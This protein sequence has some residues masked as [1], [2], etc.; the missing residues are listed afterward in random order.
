MSSRHRAR[1]LYNILFII[2]FIATTV[3]QQQPTSK[4]ASGAP[5]VELPPVGFEP[6]NN[7]IRFYANR[8]DGLRQ[9]G[10]GQVHIYIYIYIYIYRYRYIY[11]CSQA[12]EPV[13]AEKRG[14]AS[15][16][17]RLRKW[18]RVGFRDRFKVGGVARLGACRA[19]G[20][21]SAPRRMSVSEPAARAAQ[22]LR[23]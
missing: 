9:A 22:P 13:K 5:P 2:S 16:G 23:R 15:K 21:D 8:L 4:G 10:A 1:K 7:G 17:R 11:A 14:G 20:P 12:S 19:E 6:A 3:R 18:Q